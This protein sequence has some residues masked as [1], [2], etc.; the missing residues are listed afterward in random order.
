MACPYCGAPGGGSGSCGSCQHHRSGSS[1]SGAYRSGGSRSTNGGGECFPGDAIVYTEFGPVRLDRILPG[2]LVMALD[3]AGHI[4]PQS[5]QRVVSHRAGALIRIES[6]SPELGFSVTRKHP[7]LTESGWQRASKLQA[8]DL[9]FAA[10]MSQS[11]FSHR[12]KAVSQLSDAPPVY[13]LIVKTAHTYLV[14]GCIA[15]SFVN[16]RGF[17]SALNHPLKR[18]RANR[19]PNVGLRPNFAK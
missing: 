19:S 4:S 7:I 17:R 18:I 3:E 15:H 13:N 16:L 2:D 8:G 9:V 10:N 6:E 11:I 5:V 14:Q 1:V 12:I